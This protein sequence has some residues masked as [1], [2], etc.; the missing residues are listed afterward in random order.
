MQ[1]RNPVAVI[2][3]YIYIFVGIRLYNTYVYIDLD[4]F[5]EI[6][7]YIPIMII[8]ILAE[9]PPPDVPAVFVLNNF[10]IIIPS[11][12]GIMGIYITNTIMLTHTHTPIP[13]LYN[14]IYMDIN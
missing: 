4:L 7:P 12:T 13:T 10:G 6:A 14:G 2:I 8:I 9:R 3:K 1:L 11:A 5:K